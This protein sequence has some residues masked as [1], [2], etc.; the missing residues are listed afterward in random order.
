MSNKLSNE[1]SGSN[2]V[3]TG[4]KRVCK[5]SE[6]KENE[7]NRFFVDDVDVAVYKIDDEIFAMSNVCPHQHAA[8]IHS[9]F[10][11]DGYVTCPAHG[12]Q[13]NLKTGKMPAGGTGLKTYPVQLVD[14]IVY[15]K[16]EK[17]ELDW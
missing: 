6:L 12:W 8:L 1:Q 9:G 5:M 14:G 15:A 2:E 4:F 3:K 10:I 17:Q 13:F 7:G 11:E 16:V